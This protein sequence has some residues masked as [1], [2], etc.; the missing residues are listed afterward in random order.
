MTFKDYFS[1]QSADYSQYRPGYPPA[2]FHYLASLTSEHTMAWDCA[3]GS[4]QAA[5]QLTDF[6]DS[7]LA[8]DASEQQL[9]QA[10]T[11][12]KIRYQHTTAEH[13]MLA[14]NSVDLITVAQAIHWFNFERFYEEVRRVLKS[15]GIIAIWCYQFLHITPDIDAH[16][17]YLYHD[18]VGRYWPKERHYIEA[19]YQTIPF[20]FHELSAPNFEMT[21]HWSLSHLIHYLGTWSAVNQYK[22]LHHTDPVASI[23]A[24]LTQS[25]GKQRSRKV[26][27]P[28]SIRIGG[29]DTKNT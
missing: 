15:K 10:V 4:G 18:I 3:T 23:T 25:W 8:S 16:V 6:F 7:V 28:L 27:W 29:L 13:S 11:H 17:H 26:S 2:L 24:E 14:G 21:A 19:A 12:Q 1:T 5:I 22:H 20:P 9:A